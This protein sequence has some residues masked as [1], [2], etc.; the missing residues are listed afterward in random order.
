[1]EKEEWRPVVGFED[2]Y[3]VSNLGR[4]FSFHGKPKQVFGFVNDGYRYIWLCGNGKQ[5]RRP[6]HQI[7]LEA[8]VGSRPADC[9]DAAHRDGNKGNNVLNN[10]KWSTRKENMEDAIKH[11]TVVRGDN[12]HLRRFPEKRPIGRLNGAS[13]LSECQV[14]EIK[15]IGENRK[16]TFKQIANNFGISLTHARNII[17]GNR[18][19]HLTASNG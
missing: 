2:K 5:V 3:S 14:I 10:L 9:T 6:I 8:F 18:W 1:M 11:G 15:K 17:L 13:R 4:V 7:V 19:G 12:H 16:A